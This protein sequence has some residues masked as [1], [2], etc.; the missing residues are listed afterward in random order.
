ML[1]NDTDP[2]GQTLTITKA[3]GAAHG[4]ATLSDNKISYVPTSNYFGKDSFTYTISDGN[5]GTATAQVS[6]TIKP[7]NDAPTVVKHSSNPGDWTM[8]EDTTES[9]HFVVADAES[10]VSNLIIKITSLDETLVKTTQIAL[11]TNAAGYK[12]LTVTP[13][14]NVYGELDLK[15]WV[16]DGKLAGEGDFPRSRSSA[17]TDAP[18]VTASVTDDQRGHGDSIERHGD[19][20]GRRR[21]HLCRSGRS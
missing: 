4:T 13:N 21:R 18:V 12:T 10:A 14:E 3:E 8:L 2:E 6:V 7:V 16:S 9:F 15:I 20:C 11:T 5:G 19:G 17:S 1:N